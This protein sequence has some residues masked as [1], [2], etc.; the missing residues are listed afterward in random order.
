MIRHIALAVGLGLTAPVAVLAQTA[1]APEA[2]AADAPAPQ[3]MDSAATYEAARNQLG[4]L[5]YCQEQ[6]FSG[7]EAVDAQAK[8]VGMLPEGDDE[9]GSTAEQKGAEG[10]V[11]LGEAEMSLADAAESQSSN[12]E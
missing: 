8:L 11:A 12:V 3:A 10:T 9:A 4:I 2:P 6:G 1:E 5:K 7:Q